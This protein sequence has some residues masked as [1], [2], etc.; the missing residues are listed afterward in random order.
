MT[1]TDTNTADPNE[2]RAAMIATVQDMGW[3]R[4]PEV[5]RVL[6]DTPRHA[7][8]PE[9]TLET[10]YDPY[11][12]VI[13]HRFS[14]GSSLSCASAPFVVAM[15]LDQLDVQSGDRV[16]EIGAGTGYN[17][18]LLAGLTGPTGVV[19]TVDIDPDVT[20]QASRAL[21]AA[22]YHGVRV[23]TG[24]GARGVPEHAPYD[25]LIAAVSPWDIPDAW[26]DQLVPGARV[27][28][29]LRWRG[30]ARSVA[31]TYTGGRLVADSIELCGF[32]HLVGED[33]GELSDSITAD[34]TIRLHWDHDQR[35]D[36]AALGGVFDQPRVTA[37]SDVTIAGDEPHDGIW[38]RLTI[39]EPQVCR[40]NSAADIPAEVCDP[41][42]AF[43]SPAVVDGESLAYLA[44]RRREIGEATR[45]ELG[46]HG[47]GPEAE[48]LA[49]RLCS[50]VRAWSVERDRRK[51][52]LTAY[53]ADTSGIDL[54]GTVID[55]SHSRFVLGYGDDV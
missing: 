28:A 38:L 15:M 24:D 43:R 55:K 21:A 45:W 19:T 11:N 32:V 18:A 53:R 17:A 37:W 39:T 3:A 9:A 8:V 12:A 40:I 33:D 41:V 48:K 50:E 20:E 51:P 10:A 44:S 16:L 46:A 54:S 47:H 42:Q 1:G 31:F 29:P 7:F 6:R 36:P 49:E 34:D 27:V 13:T 4:R 25:R 35:I 5:E 22:G 14:D 26:W 23:V 52:Q 30:Q 2:L